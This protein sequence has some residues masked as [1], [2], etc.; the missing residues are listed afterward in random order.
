MTRQAHAFLWPKGAPARRGQVLGAVAVAA[1]LVG[2]V[3]MGGA[4]ALVAPRPAVGATAR[5]A[6]RPA[7]APAGQAASGQA[8]PTVA[9]DAR[10]TRIVLPLRQARILKRQAGVTAW[11]LELA[12][13]A[14]P[15]M[16]FD[17]PVGAGPLRLIKFRSFEDRVWIE[18]PW[19]YAAPS[20]VVVLGDRVEVRF[21]HQAAPIAFQPMAL[22]LR[23]WE[24]QRW[25]SAGPL[26]VRALK[27]DPARVRLV[28]VL[29][30]PGH[31]RMGL[32]PVSAMAKALGALAAV[33]GSFYSPAT[34][35]PQG[36]LVLDQKLVRRTM[37][38]RPAI[39]LEAD[40]TAAIRLVKPAARI[41]LED[42]ATIGCQAVNEPAKHHRITLYTPHHGPSTRTYPDESRWELAVGASGSV[43]AEGHGNLRIPGGGYVVSGQGRGADALKRAI[44]FGQQLKLVVD[45]MGEEVL[46]AMG[47][48]PTLLQDGV[49]RIL[50]RQQHF[51]PDV[52]TGRAPR[53]AFGLLRDGRYVLVTI[54]GRRPGYSVGAT[55]PELAKVMQELGAAEAIN[56]DG[57]GSTTMWLRGRTVN[58]PSDGRERPVST[59]LVVLP[60]ERG[61]LGSAF[62]SAL[63][64]AGFTP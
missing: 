3:A 60:R 23:Y 9:V 64:A 49:V 57:G 30:S 45:Q 36:L 41:V 15:A 11:R 10:L 58:L 34:G 40:G 13:E 47:G 61:L 16:Q 50:A 14:P 46:H 33:N 48:G 54:D 8:K 39:W 5:P 59:A 38:D 2:L 28:P 25:S 18:A 55:L 31:S 22:G 21:R 35:E 52:A 19:R 24:G 26:R 63:V 51:R 1:A 17:R 6:P 4:M 7:A 12:C 29:A 62:D 43:V 44:G 20:E 32:A 42:G 53:T 27:L 56:L 37:L